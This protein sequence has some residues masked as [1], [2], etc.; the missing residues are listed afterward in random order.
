[1]PAISNAPEP[2][3]PE[4]HLSEAAIANSI[5][6]QTNNQPP[7]TGDNMGDANDTFHYCG[8]EATPPHRNL[9]LIETVGT[10]EPELNSSEGLSQS[11]TIQVIERQRTS[12]IKCKVLVDRNNEENVLFT[13]TLSELIKEKQVVV[14]HSCSSEMKCL[15]NIEQM[16]KNNVLD[17]INVE[18]TSSNELWEKTKK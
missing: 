5:S 12:P 9:S 14:E 13:K 4:M 2:Q 17:F 6:P 3:Q 11:T 16:M 8:G 7:G 1:M 10:E 15:R 18:L